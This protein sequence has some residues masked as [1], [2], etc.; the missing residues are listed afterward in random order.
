M[1]LL[2]N[3]KN[4]QEQ[5]RKIIALCCVCE[6]TRNDM[7]KWVAQKNLSVHGEDVVY[8][9]GLCPDCMKS[10]YGDESWYKKSKKTSSVGPA[11]SVAAPADGR[12]KIL[13]IDD[14]SIV[15]TILKADFEYDFEVEV[16]ICGFEGVAAAFRCR[17]E[18]ILLDGDIPDMSGVDVVRSLSTQPETRNIPVIV[19]AASEPDSETQKQLRLYNN[20]KGFF[21]KIAPT[22]DLKE[23]V[24]QVLL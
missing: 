15:R 24:A 14:S 16:A 1:L 18:V 4:N 2:M 20:F 19:L 10:T 13:I 8:T 22:E 23:A 3:K 9:H 5:R 12:K 17:P 6:K 11:A 7:G 21:N